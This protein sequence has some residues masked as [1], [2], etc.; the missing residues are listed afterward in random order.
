M[1][2]K[3]IHIRRVV[4]GVKPNLSG[5]DRQGEFSRQ[6]TFGIFLEI[7]ANILTWLDNVDNIKALRKR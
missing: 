1:I 3:P 7:Q 6:P 4:T 5:F 2:K